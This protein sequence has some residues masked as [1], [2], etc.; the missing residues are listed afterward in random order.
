MIP[1]FIDI[2]SPWYVLPEGIYDS[3]FEEIKTRLGFNEHRRVLIEGLE[4]ACETLKMA[5]CKVIY[6]DGS[7]ISNKP[8]P[9]D[10]DACWESINVNP[11]LLDP[12]LLDFSEGRK[13]QKEKFHGELFPARIKADKSFTFLEYFQ[14]DKETGKKKGILKIIL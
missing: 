2:G 1:D 12:V 6:L 13:N 7:F 10:F 11:N 4:M 14:I 9:G 3:T 5:G 8:N